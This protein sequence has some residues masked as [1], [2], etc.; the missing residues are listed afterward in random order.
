[1]FHTRNILIV[2]L[3]TVLIL[4]CGPKTGEL[5]VAKIGDSPVKLEEY[6]KFYTRNAGGLDAA[7]KSTLPER[8]DFL[9]LLL[10]YKLKLQDAYDKNLANDA[11][12]KQ[13]LSEYRSSL[14]S[15]FL[16]ERELI[17]PNLHKLYKRSTEEIRA[18]HILIRCEMSASPEDTLKAYAKA[19]EVIDSLKKGIGFEKLAVEFSE[20]P[21]AKQNNGDIYYFTS[22]QLVPQFEDAVYEMKSGEVTKVP[23]RTSF[24]YH[25]IKVTD[26]KPSVGSIRIRHLMARFTTPNKVDSADSASAYGRILAM[27]DSLNKGFGFDSLAVKLSEDGGSAPNG[28]D[29]GYFSRRRW[30]QPFDEAAFK[31]K[32][33]EIS[34]IVQTPYGFHILKCEDI[35]SMQTYEEAKPD[36]QK[37]FQSQRY[38]NA[39]S[40]FITMMKKEYNYFFD[41]NVFNNFLSSL[42][43][44][45]TTS[46]SAWADAVP[47]DIR[48]S[49]IIKAGTRNVKV[50]SVIVLLSNRQDF[51]GAS[52]RKSE[53]SSRLDRVSELVLLEEKSKNLETKY[54]EFGS[55]M[56]EYQD[57]VV[58]YK[59]EQMEIWNK[60][61][62]ND[63]TLRAYF[64]ANREKFV[65]PDRVD[66]SEI[67][68]KSD[69]LAKEISKQLRDGA[70][71]DTLAAQ[72]NEEADLKAK[73]GTHGLTNTDDSE[74]AA[75]AWSMEAGVV[76]EPVVTEDAGFSIIKVN[77]KDPAHQKS[78]ED[79]GVEVSNAFQESEQK[80]L[81][82]EW[83]DKIKTKYPV[84]TNPE[85]LPKAF[86]E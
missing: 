84:S 26:K 59:A 76:S 29:L 37:N 73:H 25:I 5:V 33:G 44:S 24:G 71:Y 4:G 41:E 43:T 53:M 10:K 62:I 2:L 19:A 6:E 57:G 9:N 70:N 52:L 50:D 78:F 38:N 81:E 61:S 16:L 11:D 86:T 58:L 80:R 64:D 75:K 63:T 12:I 28:G 42:D 13:E 8:E 83:L 69:S 32:A 1:M 47:E 18:S 85:V 68:V 14:A 65:F 74:M 34:G 45:K 31:L 56:K 49:I 60:L 36:L 39:Y 20:D 7:K 23:V 40:E 17:E 79:A 66:Y 3:T 30:I 48:N 46:D 67:Y 77:S 35:K 54:P 55:L 22:G 27:K 72:Y 15:T 51:K 82:T 21:S